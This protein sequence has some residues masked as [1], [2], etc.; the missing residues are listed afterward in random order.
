MKPTITQIK[1][2]VA[3]AFGVAVDRIDSKSREEC[4]ADARIASMALASKYSFESMIANG[5]EHGG[6]SAD[7]VY[8]AIKRAPELC[9]VDRKFQ[10]K[11]D[12]AEAAIKAIGGMK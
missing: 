1:S 4:F 11:F 9:E 3:K 12:R 5:A 6:R 8:H 2:E 7:S 10:E